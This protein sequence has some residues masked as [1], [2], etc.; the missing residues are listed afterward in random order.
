MKPR[1]EKDKLAALCQKHNIQLLVLH[2]SQAKGNARDKSDI[3]IG[4]LSQGKLDLDHQIALLSDFGEIFGEKFDPVFLNGAE[5]L[6]SYQVALYGKPLFEE[7]EGTFQRF[8]IQVI[9]RYMDSKKFR[10][11]EKIYL[12]R[13]VGKI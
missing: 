1:I 12:K 2:G 4:I 7:K 8:K 9:A 3:D 10:I 13:A 5:P 6:I 11:M